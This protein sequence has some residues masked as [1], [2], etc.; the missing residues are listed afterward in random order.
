MTQP[1]AGRGRR[2]LLLI[3]AAFLVLAAAGVPAGRYILGVREQRRAIR[4]LR[5]AGATVAYDWEW[6]W[7]AGSLR[8]GDGELPGW[9]RFLADRFGPDAVASV[10]A[11][12]LQGAKGED[13]SGAGDEQIKLLGPLESLQGLRLGTF[14]ISEEGTAPIAGLEQLR[15]FVS[16]TP[17]GNPTP[18]PSSLGSARTRACS[19]S[20]SPARPSTTRTS[21]RSPASP[22]WRPSRSGAAGSSATPT[23]PSS[24]R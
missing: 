3:L 19:G 6:R 9:R 5:D 8:D 22:A 23:W 17:S 18:G 7:D 21:P 13:G 16:T 12:S 11:V 2:R 1:T 4:A 14:A 24:P 15:T 20:S 10:A